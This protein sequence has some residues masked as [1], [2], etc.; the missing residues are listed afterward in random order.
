MRPVPYSECGLSDRL[1]MRPQC[2]MSWVHSHLYLQLSTWDR[3]TRGAMPDM[4]RSSLLALKL[5]GQM[6]V[7]LFQNHSSQ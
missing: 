7:L 3:I 6:G 4:N 1:S 5:F 2:V